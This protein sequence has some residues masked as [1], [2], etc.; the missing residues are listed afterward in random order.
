[1]DKHN[2]GIIFDGSKHSEEELQFVLDNMRFSIIETTFSK[3][4]EV[5]L[6]PLF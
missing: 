2:H 4:M 3:E 6:I 1:M 5:F